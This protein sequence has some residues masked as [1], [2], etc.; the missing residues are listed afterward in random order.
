LRY[1][2]LQIPVV[3]IDHAQRRLLTQSQRRR[4]N[5]QFATRAAVYP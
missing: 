3:D 5:M 4:S 2:Q 1:L